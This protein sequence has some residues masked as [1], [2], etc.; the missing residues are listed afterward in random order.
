MEIGV[1]GN[2]SGFGPEIR[3]SNLLSSTFDD[4]FQKW[5]ST[6]GVEIILYRRD[7]KG[8]IYRCIDKIPRGFLIVILKISLSILFHTSTKWELCV[9]GSIPRPSTFYILLGG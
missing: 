3:S 5:I 6:D 8:L 2:T 1:I 9:L 7:R 4:Y